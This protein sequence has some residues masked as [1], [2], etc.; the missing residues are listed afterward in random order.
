MRFISQHQSHLKSMISAVLLCIGLIFTGHAVAQTIT[1]SIYGTVA[2]SSGAVVPDASITVTNV[3]TNEEHTTKSNGAG[4][5]IFPVLSPGNYQVSSVASGFNQT[6]QNDVRLSANQ[7]VNVSFAMKIGEATTT[8]KVMAGTTLVDTRGSTISTTIDQLRIQALPLVN[9]S[10]YDLIAL[11][12]GITKFVPSTQIG[13]PNGVQFS[14]N[15]LTANF[16]SFYLDGSFN[17]S[18][19]RG[20]G[21]VIPNPDALQEFSIIT[22]NQ[23]AEF[24]RNPG[25]VVN[26]ITRSGTNQFHGVAYDFLRNSD[27]AAKNYFANN[28]THLVYN[29]FGAGIGGPAI[30]NKLFFFLN[31]Q[32]TRI[33]TP[34]IVTSSS[35]VVPSTLER[36]GDFSQS[37]KKPTGTYCGAQYVVCTDPVAVALLQYIPLPINAAGNPAQQNAPANTS[38]DQGVARLDY[39]LNDA[40]KLQFT[41]FQSRGYSQNPALGGNQTFALSRGSIYANQ[42][43][44]VLGDTWI[45]S[46]HAVNSFRGFYTLNKF[47]TQPIPGGRLADLGSLMPE[48]NPQGLTLQPRFAITG[49]LNVGTNSGSNLNQS[50]LQYGISDTLDYLIGRHSFMFGGAFVESKY[51]ETGVY[52]G[53]TITTFTGSSTGNALADFMEGRANSFTQNAGTYYRTHAPDPSLFVQDNWRATRRL[54]LDLGVRWELFYPLAGQKAVGTFVPGVQSTRFPTA[55]LGL[56]SVGDP[57][58]PDGILH[59]SYK[60]FAPRVGFSDDILGNG[61]LALKGAY[62]IFYAVNQETFA[63]NLTQEPF[64]LSIAL[65]KTTSLVNAYTGIAPFNGVSPF[66]Y[67]LDPANPTFV[68]GASL[69]G[70]K[71]YTSATPYVQEYNLALQQQFGDNWSAQVAYIGNV[72]RK[73]YYPRDE[74]APVYIPGATTANTSIQARR[75]Y[76]PVGS[77]SM[78]DPSNSSSYNSLQVSVT[79]RFANHFSLLASYVLSRDLNIADVAPT[80][81]AAFVLANQNDPAMD[82]GLSNNHVPQTFVASYLYALPAVKRFGLFGKEVLSGWQINGI[83]TI[84]SGSPFNVLSNKDTNFD[85]IATDRPN[86]TGNPRFG[87]GRSRSQKIA[88]YFNTAAYS[89]PA[90]GQLYGN[91]SRNPF[92]GPGFVNTNLSAFKRFAIYKES[93]LLFRGEV[94]NVFNNVNLSN[95]NGTFGTA[96]FGKI[97][98]AG[99]PRIVQLALKLEF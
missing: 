80:A 76:Q 95:P 89:L 84:Q 13:E 68:A 47:I 86:V 29:V 87:S 71:P 1:G 17:S 30:H 12:P 22:S 8:V 52:N 33:N 93:D 10:A 67:K 66:P 35:I 73:F 45:I 96:N 91:S 92:I 48:G 63:G 70:L 55:P 26:A 7:N 18:F 53:S 56:L 77:I 62:G 39:Q 64:T 59:V 74:N 94:F 61:R 72:S 40:H 36:Q 97:I 27:L 75:P 6:I 57:G 38:A 69:D 78:Y 24:G 79:R 31:Y 21:N 41:F 15:G 51:Q 44:Y 32:G 90:A 4:Q 82:Y 99:D 2:D 85:G 88:G 65:N 42:S 14:S 28:V 46:P 16:N 19:Y 60:R 23:N 9:R 98:A 5:Y 34:A 49:Y 43:N 11:V 50:Q 3:G 20:G 83:T 81:G 58:V 54:T 37:A 25:A